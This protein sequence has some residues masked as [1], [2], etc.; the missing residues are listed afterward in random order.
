M[1][2]ALEK[3]QP[4]LA[5][6][7]QMLEDDTCFVCSTSL[8][9]SSKKYIKEKLIPFFKN[10]LNNNDDELNKLTELNEMFRKFDSFLFKFNEFNEDFFVNKLED[11]AE[12]INNKRKISKE[13]ETYIREN[14]STT[15]ND[16]ALISLSTYDQAILQIKQI[17]EKIKVKRAKL[18]ELEDELVKTSTSI[19]NDIPDEEDSPKLKTAKNL[20]IFNNDLKNFLIEIKKNT[21]QLFS[22]QLEAS[23]NEK[24]KAISVNNE[25]FKDQQIKVDFNLGANNEPNFEIKVVNK[26]GHSMNQGGGA[27]QVLRQ[28]SVIFGLID[29]AGGSVDYPFIADAPTD[30]MSSSLTKDFFKYQLEKATNQNILIT[31]ELWDD[32]SNQLNILGLEILENIASKQNSRLIVLKY[33]NDNSKRVE[34]INKN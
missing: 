32:E 8:N 11:I 2:F 23:S 18:R 10:E 15:I 16:N 13:K 27:S 19:S 33:Q 28:L 22:T 25:K 31:K 29:K 21:Y 9:D 12:N 34:I 14:G 26:S 30:K 6:L 1:L 20:E 3:D 17:E 5:I 24:F 4:G 7:N